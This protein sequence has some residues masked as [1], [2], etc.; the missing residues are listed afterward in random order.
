MKSPSP[1]EVNVAQQLEQC[2]VK[3]SSV[4]LHEDSISKIRKQAAELSSNQTAGSD[5]ESINA[6]VNH[7]LERWREL[8]LR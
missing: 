8:M 6:D 3:I 4:K 2:R 5:V 7:F 1:G